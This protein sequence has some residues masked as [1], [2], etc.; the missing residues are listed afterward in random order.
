M[1][2]K[3]QL[4]NQPEREQRTPHPLKTEGKVRTNG[5]EDINW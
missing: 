5:T 4:E 1:R 2:S 3:A